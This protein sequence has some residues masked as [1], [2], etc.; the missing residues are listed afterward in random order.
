[1]PTTTT[2]T[3]DCNGRRVQADLGL[4]CHQLD[5]AQ[6]PHSPARV[7]LR[8]AAQ[9]AQSP[10]ANFSRPVPQTAMQRSP[11]DVVAEGRR[12]PLDTMARWPL[13]AAYAIA[14]VA[15]TLWALL[16]RGAFY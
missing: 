7:N 12:S 4:D 10:H 1:M 9:F 14:G 3:T 11:L 2:L 15:L 6:L 16:S 8:N 5:A 13:L